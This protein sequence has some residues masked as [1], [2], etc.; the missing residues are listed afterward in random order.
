MNV[1]KGGDE[2]QSA[3]SHS[4]SGKDHDAL[5]GQKSLVEAICIQ[6]QATRL[7]GET[8]EEEYI[9]GSDMRG[10]DPETICFRDQTGDLTK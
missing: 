3:D 6:K 1:E 9:N 7:H 2:S 8:Y 10:I 4:Q 5:E